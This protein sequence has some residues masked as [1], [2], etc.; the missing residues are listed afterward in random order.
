MHNCVVSIGFEGMPQYMIYDLIRESFMKDEGEFLTGKVYRGGATVYHELKI[1]DDLGLSAT[2]V[3]G[4]G[5]IANVNYVFPIM[6]RGVAK[7]EDFLL[8]V[9]YSNDS[10]I[11]ENNLAME[12]KHIRANIANGNMYHNWL[13]GHYD[14]LICADVRL[15]GYMIGATVLL[16]AAAPQKNPGRNAL[17][18]EFIST[19]D[20]YLSP[21]YLGS[22][23]YEVLAYIKDVSRV[24]NPITKQE[25]CILD[26]WCWH[27]EFSVVVNADS[28]LGEPAPGYRLKGVLWLSGYLTTKPYVHKDL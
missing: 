2:V 27:M 3:V 18:N 26:V 21:S 14:D 4:D 19:Y 16:P 24:I 20:T 12:G 11:L 23:T 8:D 5:R 15:C 7:T 6:Y 25:V 28:I 9:D 13:A 22:E 1:S 10:F 17:R